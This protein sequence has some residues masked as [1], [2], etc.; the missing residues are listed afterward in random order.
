MDELISQCRGHGGSGFQIS[1]EPQACLPQQQT[2]ESR[3]MAQRQPGHP[4]SS[5]TLI[6]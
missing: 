2:S 4:Y 1:G 3:T 5:K 6:Q